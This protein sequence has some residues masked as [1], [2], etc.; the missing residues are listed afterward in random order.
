M[1]TTRP[2]GAGVVPGPPDLK[3]A[4]IATLEAQVAKLT[5]LV[6]DLQRVMSTHAHPVLS[7]YDTTGLARGP[8][9]KKGLYGPDPDLFTDR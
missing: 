9:S 3:D 2:T 4:R 7:G 1:K 6:G 5:A 8:A